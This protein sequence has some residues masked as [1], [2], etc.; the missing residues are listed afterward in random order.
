MVAMESEER[1]AEEVERVTTTEVVEVPERAA[2]AKCF[3]DIGQP[4]LMQ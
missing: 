1:A 4:P 3:S 2:K